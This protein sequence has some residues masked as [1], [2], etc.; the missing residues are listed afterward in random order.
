MSDLIL[1]ARTL[2]PDDLAQHLLVVREHNGGPQALWRFP[3]GRG[4]SVIRSW[5]S[6]EQV[7]LAVTRYRGAGVDA[8]DFDYGTPVA[9]DVIPGIATP[10]ELAGLLRAIRDLP[11]PAVG[12]PVDQPALEEG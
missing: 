3:N 4:A 9:R 10:A 11:R 1:S 6:H 8:W 12:E 5:V 2:L 7:E